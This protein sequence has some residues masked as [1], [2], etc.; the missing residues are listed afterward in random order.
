MCE[1]AQQLDEQLWSIKQGVELAVSFSSQRDQC[2]QELVET[3]EECFDEN[4]DGY[5]AAS[6]QPQAVR[7]AVHSCASD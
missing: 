5:G 3:V 1:E 7:R 4:W 6:V 2:W